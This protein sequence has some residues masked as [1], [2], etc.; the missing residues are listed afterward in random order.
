[1][2]FH[3]FLQVVSHKH[4]GVKLCCEFRTPV[5]DGKN[6]EIGDNSLIGE[7]KDR[8]GRDAMAFDLAIT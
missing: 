8:G 4:L 7:V 1:V 2:A 6:R 5:I 3:G